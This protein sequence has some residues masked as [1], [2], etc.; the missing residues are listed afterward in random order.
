[1]YL[2]YLELAMF[3]FLALGLGQGKNSSTGQRGFLYYRVSLPLDLELG[4]EQLFL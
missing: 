4:S 1:M 2:E 3:V